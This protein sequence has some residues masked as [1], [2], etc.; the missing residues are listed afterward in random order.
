[1]NGN[2][3]NIARQGTVSIEA[4]FNK[5][6]EKTITALV[7]AEYDATIEIDKDKNVYTSF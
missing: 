7:Y 5:A 3:H 2:C 4:S 1:M 6:I